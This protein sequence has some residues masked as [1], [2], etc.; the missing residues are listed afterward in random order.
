MSLTLNFLESRET[1]LRSRACAWYILRSW[2]Q[3]QYRLPLV[4]HTDQPGGVSPLGK[5]STVHLPVADNSSSVSVERNPHS[6]CFRFSASCR[7]RCSA[8][9]WSVINKCQN[10][11]VHN[12]LLFLCFVLLLQT[13]HAHISDMLILWMIIGVYNSDWQSQPSSFKDEYHEAAVYPN[14]SNMLSTGL[15]LNLPIFSLFINMEPDSNFGYPLL[16]T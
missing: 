16:K 6:L 5:E 9:E 2:H 11:Q 8:I 4:Q 14:V 1:N 7:C 12:T 13:W 10:S 15:R 3:S